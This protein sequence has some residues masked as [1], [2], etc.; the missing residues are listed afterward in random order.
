MVLDYEIQNLGFTKVN[1]WS[2]DITDSYI[3]VVNRLDKGRNVSNQY[4]LDRLIGTNYMEL[5][6]TL[7]RDTDFKMRTYGF[8]GEIQDVDALFNLVEDARDHNRYI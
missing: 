8:N 6:S 7:Q 1:E 4:R 5:I 2:T 3:Y